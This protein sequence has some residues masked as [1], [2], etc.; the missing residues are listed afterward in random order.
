[1]SFCQWIEPDIDVLDCIHRDEPVFACSEPVEPGRSYCAEHLAVAV[2]R[3]CEWPDCELK[4]L[5]GARLCRKHKLERAAE[6]AFRDRGAA[7]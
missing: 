6:R 2:V 1:M 5:S 7:A 4:P 3:L